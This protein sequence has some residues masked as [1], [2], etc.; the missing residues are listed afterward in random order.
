M[1]KCRGG[2]GRRQWEGNVTKRGMSGWGD[3]P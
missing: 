1:G 2:S 3:E